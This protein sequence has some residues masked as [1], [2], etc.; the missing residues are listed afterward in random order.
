[1]PVLSK[2]VQVLL[3]P[4]LWERLR[5]I[6]REQERSFGSLVREAIQKVYFPSE[7]NPLEAVQQMAAMELPVADWDQ[8]ELESVSG[9]CLAE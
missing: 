2:R 4:P 9:G 5:Q 6:A 8:M 7:M 1:M 3:P